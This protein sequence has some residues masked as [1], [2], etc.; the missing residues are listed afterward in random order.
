MIRPIPSGA[1]L[2]F[3]YLEHEPVCIFRSEGHPS[4]MPVS[5]AP[6]DLRTTLRKNPLPPDRAK[7]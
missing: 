2:T 4:G 5:E 3:C 6:N 1:T 7:T